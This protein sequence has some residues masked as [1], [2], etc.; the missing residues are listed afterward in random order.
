MTGTERKTFQ[1]YYP[2]DYDPRLLKKE[3]GKKRSNQFVQRVMAPFNMQCNTCHEYI[4]KG[5]KFNMRRETAEGEAYLGLKIFRFY[6]RCPNCLAEISFKTDI[7]NVDYTAEHGATR[8]FEAFKFYQEQEK[9]KEAKEEAEK[10][11]AMMMLEKRMKMSRAEMEAADKLG[12]LQELSKRNQLTDP[13]EY[14]AGVD[15]KKQLSREELLKLQEEEDDREIAELMGLKRA[16]VQ[17]EDS[18]DESV[19]DEEEDQNCDVPTTSAGTAPNSDLGYTP[20]ALPARATSSLYSSI[21]KQAVSK[22][23]SL[24]SGI[25]I[26]KSASSAT[27]SKAVTMAASTSSLSALNGYGSASSDEA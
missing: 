17:E 25:I 12:Q 27:T 1:K 3:R 21:Q 5:K 4:Y 11:D 24:L 26:K 13:L 18:E 6:F 8:L 14:L 19:D 10:N 16:R 9:Q 23:R 20:T 22:P 7:E 2:A 15:M